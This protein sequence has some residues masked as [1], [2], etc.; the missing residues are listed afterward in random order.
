MKQSDTFENAEEIR[1]CQGDI[2]YQ[3][4]VRHI[5]E[6]IVIIGKGS[7]S[8]RTMRFMRYPRKNPN[9]SS[10]RISPI[11]SPQRIEKR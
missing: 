11:S 9:R 7:L 5:N 8:L 4:I 2:D 1:I 3:G 6:G 10:N